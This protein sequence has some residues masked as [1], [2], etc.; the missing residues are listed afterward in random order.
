[1]NGVDYT[2]TLAKEREYM[3]DTISKTHKAA[4]K[5]VAD[6]SENAE[7]VNEKRKENYIKDRAELQS[8]Y[9]KG[10]E[11]L[12]EKTASTL[13]N[14]D[15]KYQKQI[16]EQRAEFEAE[17]IKKRKDFDQRLND[18]RSSYDKSFKSEKATHEDLQKSAKE[19]YSRNVTDLKGNHEKQIGEFSDRVKVT[20]AELKDKYSRERQ[21]LVR[22][23]EDQVTDIYKTERKRQNDLSQRIRQEMEKQKGIHAA[24]KDQSSKYTEQ[25]V[26]KLQNNYQDKATTLVQD[27][28]QKNKEFAESQKNSE[29]QTNREHKAHVENLRRDFSKEMNALKNERKLSENDSDEF[30]EAVHKQ[31]GLSE[32]SR[33]EARIRNLNAANAQVKNNYEVRT[34]EEQDLNR[35]H[36]QEQNAEF[37]ETL[38]RKD[39]ATSADKLVAMTSEREKAHSKISAR[40]KQNLTNKNEFDQNLAFEKKSSNEKIKNIKEHFAKSMNALEEK[41]QVSMKELN[42]INKKDKVEFIKKSNEKHINDMFSLKRDL[43]QA[44]DATVQS[45]EGRI[46]YLKKEN[47]TLKLKMDQKVSD[48]VDYT[49]KKLESQRTLYEEQRKAELND[50]KMAMDERQHQIKSDTNSIIV[51]FQQKLEKMQTQF[52][53]KIKLLTNDYENKLREQAALN[54]KAVTQK[55]NQN[56]LERDN[57]RRTYEQE[58]ANMIATFKAHTESLKTG[59]AEQMEQMK[60]YKKLS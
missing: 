9:E 51:N 15:D 35:Q 6:V 22:A 12:K 55:D 56:K 13:G 33:L 16:G 3:R 11:E 46:G 47:E 52:D 21:D 59:H 49:D 57:L 24:E 18:I 2:K 34:S 60:N 45:Y 1:M 8:S 7:Q 42:E 50:A 43:A 38:A 19:K 23:Q 30:K 32:T 37:A 41:L 4:E 14:T 10:M 58:K 31:S 20:G 39:K 5:R 40:E 27:Y 54:S 17:S 36:M 48:I 29:I 44:M 53:S 25:K 28:G 26:S